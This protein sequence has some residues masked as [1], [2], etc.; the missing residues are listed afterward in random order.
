MGNH[1]V[2]NISTCPITNIMPILPSYA[3]QQKFLAWDSYDLLARHLAHVLFSYVW[4][5]THLGFPL[6]LIF[7]EFF[8]LSVLGSGDA[9][10]FFY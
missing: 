7:H 6:T 2:E 1:V 10:E 9:T 5:G 3:L 8:L 4:K